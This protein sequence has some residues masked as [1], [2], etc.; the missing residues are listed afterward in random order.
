MR[1]KKS[2]V[3]DLEY[4][5]HDAYN[6]LVIDML[7][8]SNSDSHHRDGTT[9]PGIVYRED[10]STLLTDSLAANG[11]SNVFIRKSNKKKS[12]Q[13]SLCPKS[14]CPEPFQFSIG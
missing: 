4:S 2:S 11:G 10:S 9:G 3:S 8:L 7:P 5:G 6:K 1:Y 14:H 13:P 12:V